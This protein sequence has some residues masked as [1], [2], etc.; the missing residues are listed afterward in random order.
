MGIHQLQKIRK[1]EGFSLRTMARQLGQNIRDTRSQEDPDNDL[2]ISELR[3]WQQILEVPADELLGSDDTRHP[4]H[5][6]RALLMLVMK[7]IKSLVETVTGEN[8]KRILDN[9]INRLTEFMPELNE[10]GSWHTVGQRRSLDD[11]GRIA[12]TVYRD[13]ATSLIS[14]WRADKPD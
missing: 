5:E 1:R 14:S 6:Q 3:R 8:N 10:V 7:D 9:L 12:E 13:P 4:D 11:M 2:R